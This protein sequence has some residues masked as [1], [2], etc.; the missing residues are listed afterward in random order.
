M[1]H[2][3]R[4]GSAHWAPNPVGRGVRFLGA[5]PSLHHGSGSESGCNPDRRG[6][7]PRWCSA[8]P[9]FNGQDSRFLPGRRGFESCRRQSADRA[10]VAQGTVHPSPKRRI[11]VRLLVGAQHEC[12]HR[13]RDRTPV[14]GA[15]DRG[16]IPRGGAIRPIGVT[17]AHPVH[18]RNA[19]VQLPHR[20][21]RSR[22]PRDRTLDYGSGNGGS[23]P[24][25]SANAT[26]AQRE[27]A[28]GSKSGWWGFESLRWHPAA[29]RSR[30]SRR[31]HKPCKL[32]RCQLPPLEST[33][34]G[35]AWKRA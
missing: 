11:Q 21:P 16:S 13:P 4:S 25:G 34:R 30:R 3:A 22:R 1:L 33:G 10:S 5:L 23:N 20:P 18:T 12:R 35:A 24:S 15:G 14:S 8:P 32:V 6:S 9:S 7:I 2:G 28:P 26:V 17:E 31:P 29:G 27:D 19:G